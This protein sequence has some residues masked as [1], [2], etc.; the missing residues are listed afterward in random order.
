MGRAAHRLAETYDPNELRRLNVLGLL[1]D[2]AEAKRWYSQAIALGDT[3]A[4]VKLG[5][6]EGK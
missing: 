2:I 6:L 1:P 5:R 4:Q 3:A